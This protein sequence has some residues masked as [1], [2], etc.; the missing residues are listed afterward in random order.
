M[1]NARSCIPTTGNN[2]TILLSVA[3]FWNCEKKSLATLPARGEGKRTMNFT[4]WPSCFPC[5]RPSRASWTR[6]A[7]SVCPSA[8]SDC[9]TSRDTASR[10]GTGTLSTTSLSK[11]RTCPTFSASFLVEHRASLQL[12]IH[13]GPCLFRRCSPSSPTVPVSYTSTVGARSLLVMR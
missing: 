7:S 3:V 2:R 1:T 8:T 13:Y 5:Q 6:R 4:S 11:V 12:H 9:A 10:P